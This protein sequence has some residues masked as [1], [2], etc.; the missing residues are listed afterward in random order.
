MK[1]LINFTL[2]FF[3]VSSLPFTPLLKKASTNIE[4][5]EINYDQTILGDSLDNQDD[6]VLKGQNSDKL[7]RMY[8][9][10]KKGQSLPKNENYET[11]DYV[12]KANRNE[13]SEHLVTGIVIDTKKYATSK[14]EFLALY[15]SIYISYM[16][17]TNY[18]DSKK[19]WEKRYL[20]LQFAPVGLA[21]NL[22]LS[23]DNSEAT[24]YEESSSNNKEKSRV[25]IKQYW[26]ND[27]LVINYHLGTWYTWASGSI[28]H[29]GSVAQFTDDTYYLIS[30]RNSEGEPWKG[31]MKNKVLLEPVSYNSS[32]SGMVTDFEI[33]DKHAKPG[34]KFN[35][36]AFYSQSATGSK[37]VGNTFYWSFSM[38]IC[39]PTSL[40][41]IDTTLNLNASNQPLPLTIS[42][43]LNFV[44]TG[45]LGSFQYKNDYGFVE[46]SNQ[47]LVS[48]G[49]NMVGVGELMYVTND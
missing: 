24:I 13:W 18:W 20:D 33:V 6:L 4:N 29:H 47:V 41:N 1:R 32:Y 9:N 8:S 11:I 43:N 2:P 25:V 17:S 10:S 12:K 45:S 42:R 48:T 3:I 35:F 26:E 16:L 37:I 38:L 31:K 36:S 27:K 19:G 40:V 34:D 44:R 21:Y 23:S 39:L 14:E 30:P 22:A 46:N 15:P 49:M 5:I 7:Y 28:Y